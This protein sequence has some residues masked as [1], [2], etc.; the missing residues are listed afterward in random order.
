MKGEIG[1]SVEGGRKNWELLE[2]EIIEGSATEFV[3]RY[4]VENNGT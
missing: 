2:R 1:G 3:S 4:K